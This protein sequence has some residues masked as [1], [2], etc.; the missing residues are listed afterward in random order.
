[1]FCLEIANVVVH[2]NCYLLRQC[3]MKII[4]QYLLLRIILC[5]YENENCGLDTLLS[6]SLFHP[7]KVYFLNF[8]YIYSLKRVCVHMTQHVSRSVDLGI[9][10]LLSSWGAQTQVAKFGG[11]HLY[12]LS[13]LTCLLRY[14]IISEKNHSKLSSSYKL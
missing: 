10:F 12:P 5:Y 2:F 1:M 3:R 11:K 9:R 13:H 8:Y 7:H 6:P 14:V 4:L